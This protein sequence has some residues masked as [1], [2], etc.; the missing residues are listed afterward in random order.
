M[1]FYQKLGLIL[2][3][4][5]INQQ[6]GMGNGKSI[7]VILDSDVIIH[8]IKGGCLN[9]LPKILPMYSFVILNMVYDHELAAAHRVIIQNTVNLLK[10]ITIEEWV[11]QKEERQEFIILQKKF[12]LGES[13]SMV[14]CKYRNDVLASSNLKDIVDYCEENK[15][16]YFTTMDFLYQAMV[17]KVMTEKECDRFIAEVTSKGSKLPV[18]KMGGFTPRLRL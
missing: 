3:K 9:L 18:T 1:S 11:P 14:Y 5:T 7:K 15:I 4:T 6:Q 10:T 13:A 2:L 16:T 8:F 17:S 12:G